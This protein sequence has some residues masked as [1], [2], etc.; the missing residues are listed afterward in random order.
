MLWFTFWVIHSKLSAHTR[1]GNNSH[2]YAVVSLKIVFKPEHIT[3]RMLIDCLTHH[4]LALVVVYRFTGTWSTVDILSTVTVGLILRSTILLKVIHLQTSV[5]ISRLHYLSIKRAKLESK[6]NQNC[7]VPRAG[8]HFPTTCSC[9]IWCAIHEL[10]LY[11]WPNCHLPLMLFTT[12]EVWSEWWTFWM[13]HV[14]SEFVRGKLCAHIP[15]KQCEVKI[16]LHESG[17][18]KVW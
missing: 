17:F 1:R 9:H 11:G 7:S 4:W 16:N 2:G 10:A 6:S 12:G 18:I 8:G 13:N 15:W 3:L 14:F 5:W